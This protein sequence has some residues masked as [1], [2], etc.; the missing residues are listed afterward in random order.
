MIDQRTYAHNLSCCEIRAWKKIQ[1]WTGFELMTSTIPEQCSTV[2][3]QGNWELATLTVRN[4]PVEYE[5]YKYKQVNIWR[6]K[7]WTAETMVY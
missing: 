1:V 3:Y 2:K 7:I 5:E 6:L 4:I